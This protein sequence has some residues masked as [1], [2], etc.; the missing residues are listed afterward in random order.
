VDAELGSAASDSRGDGRA[1]REPQ[2]GGRRNHQSSDVRYAT[3]SQ[4]RAIR[5]ICHRQGLDVRP[6]ASE[7]FRV[8]DLE[9]LTLREASSLIDDLTAGNGHPGVGGGQ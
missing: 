5:A 1:H 3:S 8:N 4:A 6:V 9:E 7:R 2:I